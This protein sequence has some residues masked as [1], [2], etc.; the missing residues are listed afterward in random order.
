MSQE[1]PY[2]LR[3]FRWFQEW[4][5]CFVIIDFVDGLAEK[6]SIHESHEAARKF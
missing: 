6:N 4:G 2:N 5:C 3:L 1:Q